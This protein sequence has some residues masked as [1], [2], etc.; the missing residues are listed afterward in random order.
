MY[1]HILS[2]KQKSA[3]HVHD[4]FS[5][6]KMKKITSISLTFFSVN[7]RDLHY[8]LKNLLL[9]EY[10]VLIYPIPSLGTLKFIAKFSLFCPYVLEFIYGS[11]LTEIFCNFLLSAK[12][13]C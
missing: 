6:R 11:I 2:L 10:I 3:H 8:H 9:Y 13:M 1:T 4:A 12:I 5:L 7:N